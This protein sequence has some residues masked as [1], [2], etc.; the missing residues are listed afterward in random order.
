MPNYL[1]A[2]RRL[3]GNIKA[4]KAQR[5]MTTADLAK[6]SGMAKSTLDKRLG[7]HVGDFTLTDLRRLAAALKTTTELLMYGEMTVPERSNPPCP[8]N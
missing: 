8:S 4:Y 3:I 6:A 7:K 2:D 5:G 1:A